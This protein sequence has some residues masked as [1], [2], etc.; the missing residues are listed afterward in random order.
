MSIHQS[1]ATDYG[2]LVPSLLFL[3]PW[4]LY[5]ALKIGKRD[6]F[7]PPGPP[8]IPILGNL[9]VFP[10]EDAY[11]KFNEWAR[12][13]G[14]I[15]SLK[16]GPGTAVVISSMEAVKG[17]MEKRSTTTSDRPKNHMAEKI[18]QGL[19]MVICPYTDTWR[20]LRKASHT[21]LTAKA[22][23]A[24][25]P[26]QR[27]EACQVMHDLLND[28]ENFFKYV[29]RYSNSVT[30]SILFGKRCPRYESAESAA[31]FRANDSWNH[32]LS[33]SIPP[34]DLFPFLD[35]LP[36]KIAWWKKLARET[37]QLQR[38]LYFGLVDECEARMKRGEH[39]GA[40]MEDLL[41]QQNDLGLTR[42][43]VG[44]LGGVLLEG[45]SETTASFLRS[46]VL[47][48]AAFPDVQRKAQE[49]IDRVVGHERSPVLQDIDNLPYIRA[50]IQE[51]HRFHPVAPLAIPHSA[52]ADEEYRGYIIP[53]DTTIFVNTYAIFHNPDYFEDPEKFNP[54]RYMKQEFGTKPGVDVRAFRNNISFGY[55]RRICPGMGLGENSLALN[56]MNFVWAF[57]FRPPKDS[58]GNE[59][60]VSHDIYE[61]RPRNASVAEII[62]REFHES[63]ETFVKF[64]RDLAAEDREWVD[65]LRKT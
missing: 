26:I 41:N 56:T 12:H 42:E 34:V 27:A 5:K 58:M 25:L 24:H 48:L 54:D 19:N 32:A 59:I 44:Y 35:Y 45:G 28:P 1:L 62:E 10:L 55:G 23:E 13:Y 20:A 60:P 36:E 39:N 9:H 37:R 29:G 52:S 22:V 30:M 17:L 7:L 50:L 40:F 15:F 18:T 61:K 57:D 3:L 16:I 33:P 6:S 11:L 31:F 4:I 47:F 2:L 46:L 38:N 51:A 43:L 49:E 63:T 14:D 64:E 21:I 65:N 53:K 8:T